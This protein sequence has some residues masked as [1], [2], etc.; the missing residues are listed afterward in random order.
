MNQ[1][2]AF[3]F[4]DTFRS[5]TRVFPV[6]GTEDEI[7]DMGASYFKTMMRYPLASVRDGAEVVMA[8]LKRFPKPAEWIECIPRQRVRPE[9]P[10]M[11]PLEIAEHVDAEEKFY[12]GDPCG[13]A[14]CREAGVDH[15]FIR[16]VPEFDRNDQEIRAL[17]YEREV[18]RGHWA[19]GVEL[20]GYYRAKEA[21]WAKFHAVLEK[22]AMEKQTRR[23]KPFETRI[24]EIFKKRPA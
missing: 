4:M 2:D 3:A 8:R 24:D 22:K 13:C 1:T 14:A 16:F 18:V 5:L 12:E 19:H 9:L 10:K 21:F 23:T 6:R 11:T 17:L 20:A 7:R 15:R